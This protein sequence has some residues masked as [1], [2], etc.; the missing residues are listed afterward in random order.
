M[1]GVLLDVPSYVMCDNQGMVNNIILSKYTLGQKYN[2]L[3]YHVVHEVAAKGIL[4]V[5]KE[6]TETNLADLLTKILGC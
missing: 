1:F 5:Q 2:E 3:N 6:D 4:R